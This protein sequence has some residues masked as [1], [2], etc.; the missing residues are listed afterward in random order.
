MWETRTSVHETRAGRLRTR[1]ARYRS[2]MAS[3]ECG[4]ARW[5]KWPTEGAYARGARPAARR[6]HA[7][8]SIKYVCGVILIAVL[9]FV[10]VIIAGRKSHW[11]PKTICAD[12]IEFTDPTLK[13]SF[14]I[15]I[16]GKGAIPSDGTGGACL[17]A[18]L[19]PFHMPEIPHDP[20]WKCSANSDCGKGLPPAWAGYGY[21]DEKEGTCWVRPGPPNDKHLC[22]KSPEDPWEVGIPHASNTEP[23]DLSANYSWYAVAADG[24][25]LRRSFSDIFPGP[26]RWRVVACLNTIHP[27]NGE[28]TFTNAKGELTKGCKEIDSIYRLEVFGPPTTVPTFTVPPKTVPWRPAVPPGPNPK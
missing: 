13:G 9:V 18:D 27:D 11:T 1:P 24:L 3:E 12:A 22:N 4:N 25:V 26:V 23:F 28:T 2:M 20:A 15:S 7:T 16:G 21:C 5:E 19:N 14:E 10:A 6:L 8:R 17:V